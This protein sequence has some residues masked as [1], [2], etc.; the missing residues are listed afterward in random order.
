MRIREQPDH[1][2]GCRRRQPRSRV[3]L[4]GRSAADALEATAAHPR[5]RR[6]DSIR[7]LAADLR[8]GTGPGDLVLLTGTHN[9]DHL[10]RI[11]L[12]ASHA[13]RCWR[14]DCRKRLPCVRCR[15]LGPRLE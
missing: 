6:Y 13:V 3:L 7:A 10:S 14:D 15:L 2:E 12:Q 1:D 8:D 5:V 11:P 9:A 4:V